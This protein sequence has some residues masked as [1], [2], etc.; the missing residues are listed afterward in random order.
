MKSKRIKFTKKDIGKTV[1][2][3]WCGHWNL[4][5]I[6]GIEDDTFYGIKGGHVVVYNITLDSRTT[7]PNDFDPS[8]IKYE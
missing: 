3:Y 7:I 5:E 8:E 1:I 6:R 2:M 4:V